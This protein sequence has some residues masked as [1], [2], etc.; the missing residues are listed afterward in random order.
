MKAEL[1]GLEIQCAVLRDDDLAVEHALLRQL[2]LHRLEQFRVIAGERF[3]VAALQKDV[4]AITEDQGTETVPLRLENPALTGRQRGDALG[5]H[6]QDGR[7]DGE[8]HGRR[9]RQMPSLGDSLLPDR[10]GAGYPRPWQTSSR[11]AYAA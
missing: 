5:E 7:V 8:V 9:F 4:V 3:F 10:A 1:E 2:R 6:G 11:S